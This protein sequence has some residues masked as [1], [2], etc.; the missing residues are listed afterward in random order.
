MKPP[1]SQSQEALWV[2]PNPLDPTDLAYAPPTP[3]RRQLA[4]TGIGVIELAYSREQRDGYVIHHVRHDSEIAWVVM[5]VTAT[6]NIW[7]IAVVEATPP[8]KKIGR[9]AYEFVFRLAQDE[10]DESGRPV[11]VESDPTRRSDSANATWERLHKKGW[12]IMN[13]PKT[14]K[15]FITF[16]PR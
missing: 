12:P 8:G 11:R 2:V 13:E 4:M 6:D 9:A 16:F 14:E 5:T 7:D 1:E 15:L 10:A 3:S